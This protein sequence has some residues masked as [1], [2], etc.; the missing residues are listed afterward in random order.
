MP[1]VECLQGS[2]TI[3][4][5]YLLVCCIPLHF[6]L[7]NSHY[8]LFLLSQ[9]YIKPEG[10]K[11]EMGNWIQSG[12]S[13]SKIYKYDLIHDAHFDIVVEVSKLYHRS[14]VKMIYRRHWRTPKSTKHKLCVAHKICGATK[15]NP[16]CIQFCALAST[17]K[18]WALCTHFFQVQFQRK[19][20]QRLHLKKSAQKK[21]RK[22]FHLGS[23]LSTVFL[24]EIVEM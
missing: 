2:H 16:L 14:E 6:K 11:N 10:A 3:K 5:F 15:I 17:T 18:G 23:R 19:G 7:C 4:G 21:K 22:I 1:P 24:V 20:L 12:D 13:K 9:D 8:C